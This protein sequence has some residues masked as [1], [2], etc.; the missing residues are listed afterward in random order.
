MIIY[1]KSIIV[2]LSGEAARDLPKSI[3]VI[4]HCLKYIHGGPQHGGDDPNL[5]KTK[6]GD[7][8]MG[9]HYSKLQDQHSIC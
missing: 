2:F 5:E 8:E 6:D 4:I 1:A 3:S 7:D 9:E